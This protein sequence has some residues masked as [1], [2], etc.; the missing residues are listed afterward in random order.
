LIGDAEIILKRST[1]LFETG[2][3]QLALQ[4]LDLLLN[5]QADHLEARRLR[6]KMLEVLCQEDYCLM[7]RNTWVY[8]M[9][10]DRNFLKTVS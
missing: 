10:K 8:F 5:Q 4:V 1:E 6:L 3:T 2:N 7:S 9:E